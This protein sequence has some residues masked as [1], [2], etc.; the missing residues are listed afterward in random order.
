M[1]RVRIEV[2][3]EEGK[4]W[5][6]DDHKDF[7]FHGEQKGKPLEISEQMSDSL[8]YVFTASLGGRCVENRA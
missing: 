1:R 8:L 5:V 7:G 4:R 2:R 3:E 6:G